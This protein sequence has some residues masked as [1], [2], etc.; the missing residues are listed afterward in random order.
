MKNKNSQSV[1]FIFSNHQLLLAK[2][3]DQYSPP[4]YNPTTENN[5]LSI[6]VHNNR[7]CFVIETQSPVSIDSLHGWYPLRFAIENCGEQWQGVLARAYQIMLWNLNHQFCGRCANKTTAGS[8]KL[9]KRCEQC[10]L[11]FF[12]KISPA[13]IVL[14]KKANQ[15]LMARTKS[16]PPGVYGLIAGFSE[17]GE[18]LEE[19][20][21]REVYEEV[22]L[23]VKNICYTGSQPWPF[24]DSLMLSFTA[25][26]ASGEISL[27]DGE[28]EKAAWYDFDNLPGKPT[29]LISI[30]YK[31]IDDFVCHCLNAK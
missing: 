2:N 16:F 12:P 10:H 5:I 19:T 29:S 18:T 20:I 9:E 30:A 21:R 17:P 13:V 25:E 27:N 8:E 26:Y 15:I 1:Y 4:D 14:I 6:G 23:T 22:G 7:D 31:M 28:L 11:S 24:P 3:G